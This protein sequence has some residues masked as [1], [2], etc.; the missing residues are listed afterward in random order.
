[1]T[2]SAPTADPAPKPAQPAQ[3]G[4][5]NRSLK[6]YLIDSRFQLK[7]TSFIVGVSLVICGIMG[8]FLY[9]TSGAVVDESQKVVDESKKVSEVVQMTIKDQYSDT[10]E[11]AASYA[12]ASSANDDKIAA[13]Q[14]QLVK[15]QR[16]MLTSLVGGLSLMVVLI[17]L[18]GIYFTHK[19]AGPIYKMKLLLKQVGDGKLTFR[20]GLRKGDELQDFFEAFSSMVEQLKSRQANEIALLE[21][22]IE[23]AQAAGASDDMM[24]NVVTVRDEMKRALDQ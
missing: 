7:Y 12:Q 15:R 22:A 14:Q 1:M 9:N 10:P 23:K 18:L 16:T 6:N 24:K 19:V 2:T 13:Q 17:G 4:R 3:G 21:G 20:G 8:V 11:L 5:Q